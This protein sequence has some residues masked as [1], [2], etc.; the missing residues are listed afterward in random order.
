[1]DRELESSETMMKAT[2]I[3][4]FSIAS[5]IGNF[6]VAITGFGMAIIFLLVYTIAD[7][8]GIFDECS[9]CDL[10]NA[11]FFQT[12]ALGSAVP[13]MLYKSRS[14]IREHRSK[15]LLATFIP[16]TVVGTPIGNFLQEHLPS[17]ILRTS[18][19]AVITLIICYE[20][21]KL[22]SMRR[23]EKEKREREGEDSVEDSDNRVSFPI[24]SEALTSKEIEYATPEND[25]EKDNINADTHNTKP[26]GNHDKDED[27]KSAESKSES[28]T[29]PTGL[30]L[31]IWGFILGFLSGFLGGLMGVRGPPLMVF[32]LIFSYPK[33]VVRANAVL[34]LLLNV[35]IRIIYY[36][37]EDLSGARGGIPWFDSDYTVLYICVVVFGM[38]GVPIGDYVA[39]K[40][41]QKQFNLVVAILLLFSGLSNLIKGSI[42]LANN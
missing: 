10:R 30:K 3:I 12:L 41:D 11:V 42:N 31:R 27:S 22:V 36:T 15:E 2:P 17:D 9:K 37:I 18:V 4:V 1:M 7:L 6:G 39:T 35:G 24:K 8:F 23:A 40:L 19:G 38:L 33:N 29:I 32:F 5:F 28:E 34:I 21:I 26:L 13:I 16:A 20:L 14:I 25:E